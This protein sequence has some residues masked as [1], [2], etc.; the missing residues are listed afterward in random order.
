MS[1]TDPVLRSKAVSVPGKGQRQ[2]DIPGG[3]GT[4]DSEGNQNMAQ[5]VGDDAGRVGSKRP[6]GIG[7]AGGGPGNGA[8][9]SGVAIA[10]GKVM[11]SGMVNK[12]ASGE[13]KFAVDG[14][15]PE[16]RSTKAPNVT[17]GNKD[18]GVAQ[19]MGLGL[20]KGIIE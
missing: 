15:S 3:H 5:E 6:P 2:V 16:I 10:Q 19:D 7:N 1:I 20:G 11:G 14:T 17:H 8:A 12:G 4:P 13:G 9:G 18:I